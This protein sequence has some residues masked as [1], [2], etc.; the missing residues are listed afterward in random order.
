MKLLN[1]Y[2]NKEKIE[3]FD[4]MYNEAREQLRYIEEHGYERK[5]C[6]QYTWKAIIELMGKNI[7]RRWNEADDD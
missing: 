3:W 2:T 1:E 5:N 7:W 6:A 4:K